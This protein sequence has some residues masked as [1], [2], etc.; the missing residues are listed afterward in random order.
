MSINFVWEYLER[1]PSKTFV[2]LHR[3]V[4]VNSI[5]SVML[6]VHLYEHRFPG[7]QRQYYPSRLDQYMNTMFSYFWSLMYAL[8]LTTAVFFIV[9]MLSE[10]VVLI[11][12]NSVVF[13]HAFHCHRLAGCSK[14]VLWF[15]TR[16]K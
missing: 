8:I 1:Y 14:R 3:K 6:S 5:C 2:Q 13:Q 16:H 4:N 10:K 15:H 7:C 9:S 12:R 11:Q